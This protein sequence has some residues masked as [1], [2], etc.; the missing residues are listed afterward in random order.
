[1]HR[2][3]SNSKYREVKKTRSVNQ[4]RYLETNLT[5]FEI[6]IKRVKKSVTT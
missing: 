6:K 1:M 5:D 2:Y 3:V 4:N